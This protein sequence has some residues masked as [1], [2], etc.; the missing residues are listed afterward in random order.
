MSYNKDWKSNE[1]IIDT[2]KNFKNKIFHPT[3]SGVTLSDILIIKNWI[4]YAKYIEDNS[5]EQIY[6]TNLKSDYIYRQVSKQL[7]KRKDEL[8]KQQQNHKDLN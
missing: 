6:N 2:E 3:L 5:C 8:H 4:I 7:I 1:R